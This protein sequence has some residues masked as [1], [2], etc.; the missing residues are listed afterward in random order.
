MSITPVV[1]STGS[2]FQPLA[3]LFGGSIQQQAIEYENQIMADRLVRAGLVVGGVL[4]SFLAVWSMAQE[5]GPGLIAKA[6]EGA[7]GA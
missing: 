3:E 7:A 5:Q 4:I 6:I 2:V 1:Y